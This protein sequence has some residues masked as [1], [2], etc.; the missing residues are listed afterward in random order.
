MTNFVFWNCKDSESQTAYT[1]LTLA[2][3]ILN[4]TKVTTMF[5]VGYQREDYVN[6]L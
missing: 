3:R 1:H 5:Q 4:T 6:E 2:Q